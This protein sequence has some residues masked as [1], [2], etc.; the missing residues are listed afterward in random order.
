MEGN[1][2]EGGAQEVPDGGQVGDG[3]VVRIIPEPPY[4]VNHP[5]ADIQKD[6]DLKES[7][8]EVEESECPGNTGVSCLHV[9]D[10]VHEDQVPRNHKGN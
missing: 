1:R 8:C 10:G 4:E 5:V 9:G 7:G 2:Q 3:H 6:D